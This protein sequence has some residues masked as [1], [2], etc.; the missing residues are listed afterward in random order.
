MR[1][2][3]LRHDSS[4]DATDRLQSC[5]GGVFAQVLWEILDDGERSEVE[6]SELISKLHV[7]QVGAGSCKV[8]EGDLTQLSEMVDW[9][10]ADLDRLRAYAQVRY[11]LYTE[12]CNDKNCKC[13]SC[14][15]RNM[16]ARWATGRLGHLEIM[17]LWR[18]HKLLEAGCLTEAEA[19]A[20]LANLST[21]IPQCCGCSRLFVALFTKQLGMRCTAPTHQ[22][23][24]APRSELACQC[25]LI[26]EGK[27]V[28]WEASNHT[29]LTYT[30]NSATGKQPSE[31]VGLSASGRGKRQ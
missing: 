22:L 21:S 27:A 18:V 17:Y 8:W 29:H 4:D 15:G 24:V 26:N 13:S 12:S 19:N 16:H 31:P 30:V 9:I 20:I 14:R 5:L 7:H 23:R 28:A 11:D 3:L 2:D 1:A 25:S 6:I 10:C